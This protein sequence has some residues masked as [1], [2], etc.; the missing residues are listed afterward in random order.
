MNSTKKVIVPAEFYLEVNAIMGVYNR[1]PNFAT[2]LVDGDQHCFATHSYYFQSDAA[3]PTD[4]NSEKNNGSV[5]MAEWT[6]RLVRLQRGEEEG[7]ES[8]ETV[9]VGDLRTPSPRESEEGEGDASSR[10]EY[11]STLVVPKTLSV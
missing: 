6:N 1:L 3:G 7:K 8:V 9:C 4:N 11:C 5:M 2:Y 10:N